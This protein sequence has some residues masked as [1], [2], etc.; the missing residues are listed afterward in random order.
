MVAD[1]APILDY[2]SV[3]FVFKLFTLQVIIFVFFSAWRQESLLTSF[4]QLTPF[5]T[6]RISCG[7]GV[8]LSNHLS[9]AATVR[10]E[11]TRAF[12]NSASMN[13]TAP[14]R[15]IRCVSKKRR[16][17]LSLSISSPNINRFSIFYWHILYKICNN[18]LT[19]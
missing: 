14:G 18:T 3:I 6:Y 17:T 8:C 16:P 12:T 4:Y 2:A 15:F 10:V 1:A 19:K 9:R 5:T 7:P 11:M 13:D